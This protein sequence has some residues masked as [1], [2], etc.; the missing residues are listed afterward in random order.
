MVNGNVPLPHGGGAMGSARPAMSPS[1]HR[2]FASSPKLTQ[3]IVASKNP[4]NHSPPSSANVNKSSRTSISYKD[5]GKGSTGAAKMS[6]ASSASQSIRREQRQKAELYGTLPK[7]KAHSQSSKPGRELPKTPTD[8]KSSLV[9]ETTPEKKNSR[10]KSPVK[11]VSHSSVQSTEE[12]KQDI[13]DEP[14]VQPPIDDLIEK[15]KENIKSAVVSRK[16]STVVDLDEVPVLAVSRKV[17]KA[18]SRS[19]S[20]ARNMDR[21]SLSP[22]PKAFYKF[23]QDRNVVVNHTGKVFEHTDIVHQGH[24]AFFSIQ[25]TNPFD[26]PPPKQ[27]K[28]EN[29][30]NIQAEAEKIVDSLE[31]TKEKTPSVVNEGRQSQ[32]RSTGV[33]ET[34]IS[35]N[36]SRNERSSVFESDEQFQSGAPSTIRN[37]S[38][39]HA[40]TASVVENRRSQTPQRSRRESN[41][42]QVSSCIQDEVLENTSE[43]K[44]LEL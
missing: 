23:T 37:E 24:N 20:P 10:A 17:S 27:V 41:K 11:K 5:S 9:K 32:S 39:G 19:T 22:E 12:D 1:L 43:V 30:N 36:R 44:T 8:K 34:N 25:K 14:T 40:R 35:Q 2:R 4:W 3:S 26:D 13:Q 33:A 7:R 28:D 21:D 18:D 42:S 16:S 15:E 29:F 6:S 31:N 38:P